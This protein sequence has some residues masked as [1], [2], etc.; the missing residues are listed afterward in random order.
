MRFDA[1]V[2]GG[3]LRSERSMS[4]SS[5]GCVA[6][7][8]FEDSTM[9]LVRVCEGYTADFFV[10]AVNMRSKLHESECRQIS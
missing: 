3:R 8:E 10:R 6:L 1:E 7:L 9:V 2:E 5:L 4:T